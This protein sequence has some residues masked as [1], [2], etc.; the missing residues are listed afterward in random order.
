MINEHKEQ[1]LAEKRL[2]YRELV[3]FPCIL[4][5]IP[6]NIFKSRNSIVVGVTVVEGLLKKNT[7]VTVL[8]NNGALNLGTIRGI[9]KDHGNL[10]V[11]IEIVSA[12]QN[13]TYDRQFNSENI[14]VSAL[15]RQSIDALKTCYPEIC[16]RRDI[17][18]TT[19]EYCLNH[20]IL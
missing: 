9:Q 7:P 4:R 18:K 20:L 13:Y 3:V 19:F 10:D 1:I 5:I 14:M 16:K 2:T 11:A 17:Y 6:E 12:D 8:T 15:T